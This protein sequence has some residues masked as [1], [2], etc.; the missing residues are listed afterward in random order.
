MK[1]LFLLSVCAFLTFGIDLPARAQAND[2]PFKG[3]PT[4]YSVAVVTTQK[5]RKAATMWLYVDG[6]K[7]RTEQETNNGKL[8][9]IL[10][11][12]LD[13]M[14]TVIVSRKAYR[15]RPFDPS[16]LKS[17]DAY[18]LTKDMLHEKVAT[19]TIKGQVCDKYR[20]SSGTGKTQSPAEPDSAMAGFIW[21]SKSSH[22]PV[23]SKTE[24]ATTEWESLDIGPQDS[25]LFEAPAEFQE[26]N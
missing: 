2:N 13:L 18:E 6:N 16:L 8:V 7:R 21:I 22:L 15:V 12:D 23:M 9:L 5:N 26:V 19:E 3:A 1:V 20:F 25:S 10:R 17:L 11:G 14:Y 24:G 4:R